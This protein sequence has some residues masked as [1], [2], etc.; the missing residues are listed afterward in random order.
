[1]HKQRIKESYQW[2]QDQARNHYE[3]F[4]VASILLPKKLRRPISAI[5]TFARCADDIVD[6][7]NDNCQQRTY[8]IDQMQIQLEEIKQGKPQ[9]E[10][11][12][13]AL[14]DSINQHQLPISLFHDLLDA[15]RQDIN[16]TRY[17]NYIEVI[18]YCRRSANPIG[19]LMLHL[20]QQASPQNLVCSD[21][22]CSAL[23]LINFMQDIHDD[24]YDRN[25]IYLPQE[26][27]EHCRVTE[28]ML[29]NQQ[30]NHSMHKLL[31]LQYNRIQQLLETGKPLLN[32]LHG[33]F[34]L[35]I[36]LIYAGGSCIFNHLHRQK[37]NLFSQ[38]RLKASDWGWMIWHAITV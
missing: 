38:P 18:D 7:G 6:E 3:N 8:K 22:I 10:M 9:Q 5:Y 2:C 16:K 13:I 4:P 15:F 23:Q 11:L 12:F 20:H 24:L 36:R 1:M 35:E 17:Q 28:D 27:M 21:A 14:A 30:S 25:R 37:A 29:I 26:E 34:G 31:T 19:R 33:R 32:K